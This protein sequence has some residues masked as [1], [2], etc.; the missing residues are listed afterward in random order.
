[1]NRAKNKVR[2]Y[3]LTILLISIYSIICK[4]QNGFV[5]NS[6]TVD[7]SGG[8]K[9][10]DLKI[11]QGDR[12]HIAA[13]G[14]IVLRGVT[15]KSGP[16]GIEGFV[17]CRMDPVFEYGA[18]LYKIGDD[19]WGIVDPQDTIVAEQMG[20]LKFMVNDN[21]PSNDVGK[22]TINVTVNDST[23]NIA[24]KIEPKKVPVK[25]A[26]AAHLPAGGLT[27]SE[28]Q[29]VSSEN[30]FGAGTLLTSKQYRFENAAN[31]HT[32]R[33]IFKKAGVT[34]SV[35][36]DMKENQITFETSSTD[37]YEAIKESLD[38]YGYEHRKVEKKVDGVTKYENSKYSLFIVLVKFN[39]KHRYVFFIKKLKPDS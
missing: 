2:S 30:L 32:Y 15:G 22:F 27:L 35:I 19:D 31:D 14:I 18:L 24:R 10:T 13:S 33:Y 25:T 36:K 9:K 29:K 3:I 8:I 11:Y 37:N 34:S 1:M 5:K 17:N 4:A 26:P 16:E 12:V 6:Y 20:Y 39:D 23:T 28:L 7:A 38:E 21:D